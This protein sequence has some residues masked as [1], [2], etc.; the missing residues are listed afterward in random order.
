MK[1]LIAI[2]LLLSTFFMP[3]CTGDDP[4]IIHKLKEKNLVSITQTY[5]LDMDTDGATLSFVSDAG[6]KYNI[7]SHGFILFRKDGGMKLKGK[8]NIDLIEIFDRGTMA[9]TGKH[10]M[11][12]DS[13]LISGGEFFLRAYQGENEIWSEAYNSV[14]IPVE[15]TG[16]FSDQMQLFSAGSEAPMSLLNW[17]LNRNI[18]TG[19]TSPEDSSSYSVVFSG[20]RWNNCDRFYEDPRERISLDIS[21]PSKYKNKSLAVYLAIKGEKNSLGIANQGMYP[22]GLDAHLIFTAEDDDQFI[23]QIISTEI[24]DEAYSFNEDNMGKVNPEQLKDIIN[25]LE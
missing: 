17:N 12:H 11:S 7:D 18:F 21:F 15:L 9:I 22:I 10:T 5:E 19:V 1:N 25:N 14:E 23:Y 8:I 13:I 16:D 24:S 3:S 6:S 2:C 20:F 4:T